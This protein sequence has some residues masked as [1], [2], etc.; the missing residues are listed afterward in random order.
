MPA[1]FISSST[2]ARASFLNT[3]TLTGSLQLPEREQIAHEHRETAISGQGDDL[4]TGMTGLGPDGLW[5]GIGHGP[6]VERP[7]E[8]S[9][10]V[11]RQIARRPD[12]R[13]AHVARKDGVRGGQLVEHPGDVLRMDGCPAGFAC[14]E[15]I[16]ALPRLLIVLER[17]LAD[18]CRPVLCSSLGRRARRV[19]FVSPTRPWST[20]VRRPSCSPRRSIW[21]IVASLGKNCWYGKS[22]PIISKTSQFIIA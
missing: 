21:T 3:M 9:L 4:T 18:A 12:R 19:V 11:H 16:E 2:K 1:A 20:L 22:V 8:P 13:G 10:A 5:Q 15:L 6:M 14:R 7:E 17:R